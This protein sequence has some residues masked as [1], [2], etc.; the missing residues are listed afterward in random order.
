MTSM[1]AWLFSG[2]IIAGLVV[3][4][5]FNLL[6]IALAW[7]ELRRQRLTGTR[8]LRIMARRQAGFRYRGGR[9]AYNESV[10]IVR[11]V[12][13]ILRTSYPDLQVIVVSDGSTDQT[14]GVLTNAFAL[15]PSNERPA[16]RCR[17]RTCAPYS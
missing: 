4:H 5:G 6:M 1:L 15:R 10:A 12:R 11:T 2:V 13:S 3:Y 16:D 8:R 17:R 14:L 7:V 9:A